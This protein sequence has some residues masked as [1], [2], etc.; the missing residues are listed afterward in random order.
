[1]RQSAQDEGKL[2]GGFC[3]PLKDDEGELFG[4]EDAA[5]ARISDGGGSVTL[6][7]GQGAAPTGAGDVNLR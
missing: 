7:C 4:V 1:M 3:S 2:S 5:G 6:R